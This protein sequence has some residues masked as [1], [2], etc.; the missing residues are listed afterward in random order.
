MTEAEILTAL[1][2]HAFAR[3]LN[4]SHRKRLATGACPFAL[5]PEELLVREGDIAGAFY[6]ILKGH[7]A[8][9]THLGERGAAAIQTVGP[10]E[11]VGWSWLFPQ[12][13]WHFDARAVDDLRAVAFDGACLRGKCEADHDLG[14]EL[15]GRFASVMIDR[16]QHTRL[17]L[18]DIYG[19][20]STS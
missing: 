1:T 15:V 6:L 7:V 9:G 20:G 19:D 14:Y 8:I 12:Y 16:L 2:G 4:E 17:R 3:E 10:G 18:L 13:V 11:I 5:A